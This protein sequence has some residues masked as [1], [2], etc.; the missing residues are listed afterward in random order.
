[1]KSFDSISKFPW[2]TDQA[3]DFLEDFLKKDTHARVL[4][5][6]SGSS[7]LWFAQRTP[8]LISLE[9]DVRWFKLIKK[10]LEKNYSRIP[11]EQQYRLVISE[12]YRVCDEFPDNYFD[13]ILVDGKDR[14]KCVEHAQRILKPGGILMLDNA[15]REKYQPIYTLLGDW[16]FFST[17]QTGPSKYDFKLI[18]TQTNWWIKP[19]DS[20]RSLRSKPKS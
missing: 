8:H 1:M 6:G 16:Q 9:H 15:E 5:F 4:E 2:L 11:C 12:Y 14:V 10:E 20:L 17:E 18:G 3:I 13:L 7:T 19:F